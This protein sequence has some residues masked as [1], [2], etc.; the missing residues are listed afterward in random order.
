MCSH[1]PSRTLNVS[2]FDTTKWSLSILNEL[3]LELTKEL[4]VRSS[5]ESEIQVSE[6]K[7]LQQTF[8]SHPSGQKLFNP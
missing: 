1:C 4:I 3:E 6:L 8:T 2:F 5:F 7:N